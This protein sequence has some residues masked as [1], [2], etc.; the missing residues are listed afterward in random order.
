MIRLIEFVLKT[1][2]DDNTKGK[3][4]QR[5]KQNPVIKLACSQ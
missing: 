5:W 3:E 1:S 2:S 4:T